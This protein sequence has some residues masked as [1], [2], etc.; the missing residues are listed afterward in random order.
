M[1]CQTTH[2]SCGACCGL[3]NL[4]ISY[5]KFKTWLD[6]T[7]SDFLELDL[8]N[9]SN[10]VLFRQQKE[11]ELSQYLKQETNTYACPFLGW[12]NKNEQR[13]GCLLHP[14]GSPHSQ[15][16]ILEKPQ[17]FSFYGQNIC[18]MYDCRSKEENLN[19]RYLKYIPHNTFEDLVTYSLFTAN[20]NILYIMNFIIDN[21]SL[22]CEKKLFY[23]IW[24]ILQRDQILVTSFEI[25]LNFEKFLSLVSPFDL[26]GSL[27][28][29]NSFENDTF[30]ISKQGRLRGKM[31]QKLCKKDYHI[32]T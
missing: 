32:T 4:K 10:I 24:K 9:I 11:A 22:Y 19:Q 20:Y 31:I 5:P 15:I 23:I 30:S 12:I 1:S 26:L 7:T 27:L 25:I 6:N 14:I 28:Y 8:S 17:N 21:D 18:Q 3:H 13:I 2:N 29:N 16:K